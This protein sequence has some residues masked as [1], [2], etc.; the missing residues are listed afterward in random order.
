MVL[1]LKPW[2]SRSLPGLQRTE[3]FLFD[4]VMNTKRR[5]RKEAA[6]LFVSMF[7]VTLRLRPPCGS[8]E[9]REVIGLMLGIVL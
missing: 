6:F 4:D 1:W 2:E 8:D 9:D 5:F 3:E 7:G